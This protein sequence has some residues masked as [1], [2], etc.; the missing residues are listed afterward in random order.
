M[1]DTFFRRLERSRVSA[2]LKI[3]TAFSNCAIDDA[4]GRDHDATV[5][6]QL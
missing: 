5:S 2:R 4:L 6:V 3:R 1:G